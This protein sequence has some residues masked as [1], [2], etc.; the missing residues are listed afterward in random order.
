ML[1][2]RAEADDIAST[3]PLYFV[4]YSS[5]TLI[6]TE[7]KTLFAKKLPKVLIG[8]AKAGQSAPV[9]MQMQHAPNIEALPFVRPMLGWSI[10]QIPNKV[11]GKRGSAEVRTQFM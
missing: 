11:E 8:V 3:A 2:N 9:P 1:P 10:Y 5:G 4:G 7:L 6:Y